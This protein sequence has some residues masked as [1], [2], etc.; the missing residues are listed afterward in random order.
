VVIVLKKES[1]VSAKCRSLILAIMLCG[2]VVVAGWAAYLVGD[3]AAGEFSIQDPE[4]LP[5]RI[6]IN[7]T[8]RFMLTDNNGQSPVLQVTEISSLDAVQGQVSLELP[9][10]EVSGL[11]HPPQPVPLELGAERPRLEPVAVHQQESRRDRTEEIVASLR[12]R[13]KLGTVEILPPAVEFADLYQ[14][15]VVAVVYQ[16]PVPS[17]SPAE[18]PKA[19]LIARLGHHLPAIE[20]PRI[21]LPLPAGFELTEK[22]PS[23]S[24][25][26]PWRLSGSKGK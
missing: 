3:D 23:S 4:N 25:H 21:H 24:P 2:S 10:A 13:M 8:S 12:Q 1:D 11:P 7:S 17:T 22:E 16:Q 19:S 5:A 9:R 6:D 14:P 18:A 20:L 26:L 15:P